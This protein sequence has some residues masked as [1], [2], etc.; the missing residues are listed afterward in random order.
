M[1]NILGL[2]NESAEDYFKYGVSEKAKEDVQVLIDQRNIA[3]QEKDF[4]LADQ[5]RNQLTDLGIT[6][7]DKEGKTFWKVLKAK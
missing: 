4:E 2:L 1:F 7:E 6:L 3:R 5:I